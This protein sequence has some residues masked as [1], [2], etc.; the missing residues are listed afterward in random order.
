LAGRAAHLEAVRRALNGALA[1]EISDHVNGFCAE[2][3]SGSVE[4]YNEFSLQH[5]FGIFLRR[6]FP[7]TLKVQFE[8]NVAFFAPNVADFL[9]KEIDISVF[10]SDQKERHAIELKFPRNGQYPEQMFSA[11]KDIAFLEQLVNSGFAKSWFIILVDDPLFY[12]GQERTGIYGP[13]RAA[14]PITGA[15]QKPTGA[16]D[17]SIS[18]QGQYTLNWNTVRPQMKCAC[19]EVS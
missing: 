11:Y 2:I 18:I 16:R 12:E 3:S 1:L 7:P 9:K 14:T 8:R 19:V 15:I 4:L 17:Q 6:V 10:T 5:E 13:F